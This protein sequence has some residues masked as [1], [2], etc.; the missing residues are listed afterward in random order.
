MLLYVSAFG[1][2]V[3]TIL[4]T[5]M[6]LSAPEP[7]GSA[8]QAMNF[9]NYLENA[10]KAYITASPS[11][12][13]ANIAV[14]TPSGMVFNTKWK[15]LT[16]DN[17]FYVYSAVP[18]SQI[19]ADFVGEVMVMSGNNIT[20]GLKENGK[21]SSMISGIGVSPISLPSVIPDGAIVSINGS[22]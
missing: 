5:M 8:P 21:F 15:N 1:L 16:I 6:I 18:A 4:I 19:A 3:S 11:S 9:V 14:S 12:G 17:K 10:N 7:L 13:T 20:L 22:L 2:L